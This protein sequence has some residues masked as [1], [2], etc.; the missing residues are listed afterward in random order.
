MCVAR[1]ALSGGRVDPPAA[2]GAGPSSGSGSSSSSRR[3]SATGAHPLAGYFGG[4]APRGAN[5]S[6]PPT[7]V[8]ALR[9]TNRCNLIGNDAWQS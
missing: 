6:V 5:G 7:E 2:S 4:F 9:K 3:S 1:Q 8:G